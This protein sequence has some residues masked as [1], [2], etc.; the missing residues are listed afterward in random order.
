MHDMMNYS[1]EFTIL[2][3]SLCVFLL[4]KQCNLNFLTQTFKKIKDLVR[5]HY[6]E[7]EK[8]IIQKET[9]L[10][11]QEEKPNKRLSIEYGVLKSGFF[12]MTQHQ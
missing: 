12:E 1:N 4:F 7:V 6:L 9:N 11:P 5:F 10:S 2:F 8:Q 3:F